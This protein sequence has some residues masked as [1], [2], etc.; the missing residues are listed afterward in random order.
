MSPPPVFAVDHSADTI[1]AITGADRAKVLHSF[2]T[3]DIKV[4][5]PGQ[6]TEAFVTS[7]QGK[8]IGHVIVD[9]QDDRLLLHT[10]A[11][12]AEKLIKHLDRYI[13]TEDVA[14]KEV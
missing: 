8:T 6:G 9:C 7:T 1:L 11:G 14:L 4:L 5:V 10:V 12:Q 3:N 2:C 13:I